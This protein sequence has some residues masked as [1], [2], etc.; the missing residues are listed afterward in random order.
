[1]ALICIVAMTTRFLVELAIDASN[2]RIQW[3]DAEVPMCVE[4]HNDSEARFRLGY[5]LRRGRGRAGARRWHGQRAIP[6]M[7]AAHPASAVCVLVRLCVHIRTESAPPGG[8]PASSGS[9]WRNRIARSFGLQSAPAP[10]RI[11]SSTGTAR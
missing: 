9:R 10:L 1:M 5:E 4:V 2:A 7:H 3:T 8:R 11:S 6:R